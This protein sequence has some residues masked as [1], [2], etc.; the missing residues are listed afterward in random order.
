MSFGNLVTDA[1]R[2]AFLGNEPAD[3]ALITSNSFR[4]NRQY[5]PGTKLT[6]MDFLAEMPFSNS[7]TLL[8][9][10]GAQLHAAI[11]ETANQPGGGGIPQVS[12]LAIKYSEEAGKI[13]IQS[14]QAGGTVLS[15]VQKYRVATTDFDAAGHVRVFKDAERLKHPSVGR[16]I[17]DIVL[18]HMYD[19]RS[20]AATI[21]G[22][23]AKVK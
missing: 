14:V 3:F 2:A 21:E 22:R 8:S 11:E 13:K 5:E 16:H 18:L 1:L 17:Y 9:V 6:R 19:E 12:G 23:I 20:V 4:G 15:P 7:V 10:T